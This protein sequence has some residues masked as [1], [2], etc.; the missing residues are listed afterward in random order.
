LCVAISDVALTDAS[1]GTGGEVELRG[2][3]NL[4]DARLRALVEA[5]NAERIAGFRAGG[6]F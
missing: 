2:V 6:S 5:V 1:D 4:V 3:D